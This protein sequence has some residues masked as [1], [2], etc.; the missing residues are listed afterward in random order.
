M[1]SQ[2]LDQARE[3]GVRFALPQEMGWFAEAQLQAGNLDVARSTALQALRL[4]MEQDARGCGAWILRLQGEI[5]AAQ[6]ESAEARERFEAAL[7]QARSLEMLPLVA[8]CQGD[9]RALSA[10]A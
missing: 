3:I 10:V 8:Q 1:L 9:I 5:A 2:A 4:A 6:G 7:Q